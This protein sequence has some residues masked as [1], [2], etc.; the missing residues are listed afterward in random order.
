MTLADFTTTQCHATEVLAKALAADEDV[1][2]MLV[3]WD[4]E[5]INLAAL[6]DIG[7][8]E[9]KETIARR[10]IPQLLVQFKARYAALIMTGW[11]VVRTDDTLYLN[12]VMR[13][14]QD[15][16]R[17]EIISVTAFSHNH[18][19]HNI[20][21]LTRNPPDNTALAWLPHDESG[22]ASFGLFSGFGKFMVNA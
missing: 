5:D 6:P 7:D 11:M 22:G 12:A 2:P 13:P 20:G 4:G 3:I 15:P 9:A 8:P 17:V 1:L 19:A 14:S 16:D 18:E 10:V 21:V